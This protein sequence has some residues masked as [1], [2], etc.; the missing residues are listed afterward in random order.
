MT[1][2]QIQSTIDTNNSAASAGDIEAILATF[3]PNGVL[4]GQPGVPA[5]G[6]PALRE[7]FKQFIA[8]EPKITI[9]SHDTILADD[10]AVHSST[11]KMSGKT[12]DGHLIEQSGFSVVILRKQ[13]DGRWLIV[14]DNPFGDHLLHKNQ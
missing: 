11:W 4:M 8:I 14:I 13:S 7:A 10:I 2:K 9:I 1:L 3:E 12:P 5:K 6:T